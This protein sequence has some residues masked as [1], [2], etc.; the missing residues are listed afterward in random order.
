MNKLAPDKFPWIVV[1]L[2]VAINIG[3][4]GY[5]VMGEKESETR[6]PQSREQR[7]KR[8][9]TYFQE[10]IGLDQDQSGEFTELWEAFHVEAQADR[11]ANI[12][13]RDQLHQAIAS[14]NR[15][16]QEVDSLLQLTAS[17]VI[18]HERIVM[19]HFD[20]LFAVCTPEQQAK[21]GE[22]F[23]NMIAKGPGM[24]RERPRPRRPDRRSER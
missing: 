5:M 4:L 20:K 14:P 13:L 17:R 9:I 24:D 18:A 1:A 12:Q 7:Q 6:T 8:L 19:E 10:N 3:L 22:A 11:Q 23:T 15:D 21:L 16:Q 2:M